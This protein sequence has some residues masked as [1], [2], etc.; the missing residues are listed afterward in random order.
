MECDV[1]DLEFAQ[2]EVRRTSDR[3]VSLSFRVLADTIFRKALA[4]PGLTQPLLEATKVDHPHNF[5]HAPDSK[6][7][8]STYPSYPYSAHLATIELDVET[9]IVHVINYAA[10]DDCGV[11]ISPKFVAGQLYGAIAQ[12]IGGAL[13]EHQPYESIGSPLAQS[14][15]HYLTPRATDLPKLKLRHQHT[16]SPFTLLGTKGV[17]ESGVGGAM[18]AVLNAVNDALSPSHVRI[19]QIPLSPP[20]ILQALA[21]GSCR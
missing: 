13:W 9:G 5:H 16:P 21:E 7:R 15:K 20:T 12:G 10:V 17:G 19:H 6:G 14:F 4:V 2:S 1:S 11:I 18:A 3:A 8:Y